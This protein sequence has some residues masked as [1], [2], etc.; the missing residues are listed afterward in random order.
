MEAVEYALHPPLTMFKWNLLIT[1]IQ[2]NDVWPIKYNCV[3][4][5]DGNGIQAGIKHWGNILVKKDS[6]LFQALPYA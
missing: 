3:L 1:F 4:F 6:R 2:I 5:Q